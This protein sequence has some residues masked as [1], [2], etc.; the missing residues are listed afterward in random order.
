MRKATLL[1]MPILALIFLGGGLR[2]ELPDYPT[3]TRGRIFAFPTDHGEHPEYR[4]EWWYVTGTL[5]TEDHRKQGFQVTFFR[6]RPPVD[7]NSQSTFAPKQIIFAHV[8]LSDAK[9]GK[10]LHDQ[11]AARSGFGLA[12]AK[13]G[14][15]EVNIKDWVLKGVGTNR[16][17]ATISSKE[18]GLNLIF[19][20]SQPILLQG[21]NGFSQKG[22]NPADA[23]YYYSIPQLKVSGMV[24]QNGAAQKVTGTAWLDHEWSSNYL[25]REA[26]GWDWTGLNFNDGSAL[27]AFQMRRS[28]G[29]ALWAGG[30]FRRADGSSNTL[31]PQQISFQM[32]QSW[33]SPHTEA[34]YPINQTV[35]IMLPEG[36]REFPLTPLFKDQEL[37]GRAG[38]LP[39]YW[40]GAVTT[41][42]GSGYLELTG[43]VDPLKL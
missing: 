5:D 30:T 20:L 36:P 35:K 39:V 34:I 23:S 26:V 38:G 11:R 24:T 22:P 40:E 25:S 7:Q 21:E 43:Y 18:F 15:T 13:I 3:V 29:S 1:F 28:D 9:V 19:N 32:D 16:F 6:T 8:A 12:E 17:S 41:P 10:L 2:A 4:T 42:G 27:M 37:D 31:G 14:N 33:K